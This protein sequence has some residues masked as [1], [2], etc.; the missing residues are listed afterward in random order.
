[1]YFLS[2]VL[3][4][5]IYAYDPARLTTR[6][7]IQWLQ[8]LSY[9]GIEHVFVYDAYLF[10]NESQREPLRCFIEG[11]FVTYVDWSHKA[12]PRHTVAGTQVTAYQDCLNKYSHR[13]AWQT[14]IDIDEYPVRP[15]GYFPGLFD[16]NREGNIVEKR[17]RHRGNINAELS[18][19][20]EA[21]ERQ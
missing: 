11:G 10:K 21:V 1:M 2:A 16:A 13:S 14:A 4:V 8:Y 6:D 3:V 18:L 7:M 20:G 15:W 17:I 19:P 5:R 9:A 12:R